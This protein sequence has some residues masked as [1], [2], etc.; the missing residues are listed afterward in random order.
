MQNPSGWKT[1]KSVAFV[2]A[3]IAFIVVAL[4]FSAPFI[5]SSFRQATLVTVVIDPG[6]GGIDGGVSGVKT[7]VKESELNLALSKI[8]G[9]Y[10]ESAGF[11]VIYTRRNDDGLYSAFDKN[12]KRADM[13]ARARIINR[14]LPAAVVSIHM[15]TYSSASRR[16][17]QVFFDASSEG[18]RLLAETVQ[19]NL[20]REFNLPDTGREYAALKAEKY[21]LQCTSAPAV[22]IECGFLSNPVDE[23]NLCSPEYRA[24]LAYSIFT[25]IA[26]FVSSRETV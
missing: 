12:K 23:A 2:A 11:N 3:A 4:A 21:I 10:L 15:N 26:A 6:H 16:G 22:I 25:A 7:G 18:G 1:Q 17:A 5:A 9:E 19:D 8:V 24:E 14:A 20:N 13:E